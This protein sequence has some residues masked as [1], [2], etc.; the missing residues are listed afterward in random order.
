LPSGRTG[1]AGW[2][3]T[4]SGSELLATIARDAVDLLTGPM[5]HRI[6]MCSGQRC[7]LIYVDTSRP[8]RRRLCSMEHC[9]NRHK[10]RAL[11]ARRSKEG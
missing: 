1:G 6:R 3:G 9:G 8:G 4:A 11:R 5:V 2:V 10:V 7:Y